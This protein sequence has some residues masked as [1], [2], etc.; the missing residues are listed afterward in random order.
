MHGVGVCGRKQRQ[1]ECFSS[2]QNIGQLDRQGRMCVPIGRI[3]RF[4]FIL[5]TRLVV[6]T[7]GDLETY[8]KEI[9]E[10]Y[11]K[12]KFA[13]ATIGDVPMSSLHVQRTVIPRLR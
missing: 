12:V 6:K 13:I 8:F 9:L 5:A 4:V 10:I 3:G 7:L 2:D 1:R 11:D